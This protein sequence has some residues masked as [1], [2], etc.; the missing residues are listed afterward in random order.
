MSPGARLIAVPAGLGLAAVLAAAPLLVVQD[1]DGD[2]PAGER[3]VPG[4]AEA[5]GYALLGYPATLL[6]LPVLLATIARRAWAGRT[7]GF[8]VSYVVGVSVGQVVL[9]VVLAGALVA[10]DPH[11]LDGPLVGCVDAPG[12][13]RTACLYR[14][15]MLCGYE[16]Y[17]HSRDE[18]AMRLSQ[19]VSLRCEG[20]PEAAL[21]W[22][23][24]GTAVEL[25]DRHGSPVVSE[26]LE[27]LPFPR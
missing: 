18:R 4:V 8:R 23:A 25:V 12:G 9:G 17:V 24:D 7:R 21:R 27:L 11:L 6:A 2:L 19:S 20:M 22:R 15:G 26:P 14:S 1:I 16:V 13:G 3:L 10:N 5:A